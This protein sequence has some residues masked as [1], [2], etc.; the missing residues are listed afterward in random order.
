MTAKQ[1]END[2]ARRQHR[3]RIIA[4]IDRVASTLRDTAFKIHSMVATAKVLA[5]TAYDVIVD[6]DTRRDME[7]AHLSR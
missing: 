3:E 6:D 5:L 7:G 1:A 2:P 4:E